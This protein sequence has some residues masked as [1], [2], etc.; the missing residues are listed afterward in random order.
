MLRGGEQVARFVPSETAIMAT[1]DKHYS[2]IRQCKTL[3]KMSLDR[4]PEARHKKIHALSKQKK[5]FTVRDV[6]QVLEGVP[7]RTL[8][9]DLQALVKIR[10]LKAK[11]QKKARFYSR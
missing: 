4:K 3:I 10:A 2:A 8:E 9:R 7:R 6:I 5:E 1:R 11:G